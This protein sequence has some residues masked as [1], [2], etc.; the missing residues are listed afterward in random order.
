MPAWEGMPRQWRLLADQLAVMRLPAAMFVGPGFRLA[1]TNDA[2]DATFGS[3]VLGQS[4]STAFPEFAEQGIGRSL[5]TVCASGQPLD[6]R[7]LAVWWDLEG[8]RLEGVFDSTYAPIHDEATGEVQ[9]VSVVVI[10]RTAVHRLRDAHGRLSLLADLTTAVG[11]SPGLD[12]ALQH[13]T[14]ALARHLGD[15]VVAN[16]ADPAA[17]RAVRSAARGPD[18]RVPQGIVTTA[19]VSIAPRVQTEHLD[20]LIEQSRHG[21]PPQPRWDNPVLE[22]LE[23]ERPVLR[24]TSAADLAAHWDPDDRDTLEQWEPHSLLIVPLRAGGTTLGALT[25]LATKGR[26][27]YAREDVLFV[28]D[29]VSRVAGP[30]AQSAAYAEQRRAALTLQRSLLPAVLPPI[31]GV[32]VGVRYD[33]GA[34]GVEIGC[35]WYDVV[36]LGAGRA[37][38]VV[39]DVM[40]RGVRAAAVM[41][42]LR[43]A[44]R[45][46]LRAEVPVGDTVGVLDELT[47]SLA[48]GLSALE[49]EPS[50][51]VPVHFATAAFAIW[52][53]RNEQLRLVNAG[54]LPPL[55]VSAD[56][57]VEQLSPPVVAPLGLG[58]DRP[59]ESVAPLPPGAT[60]ALYTDGLVERR[61]YSIE[62]GIDR[63]ADALERQVKEL[64]ETGTVD[65]Q[66]LADGIVS[67]LTEGG[68]GDDVALLLVRPRD[69]ARPLVVRRL[70]VLGVTHVRDARTLAAQVVSAGRTA[71]VA[72]GRQPVD[73]EAV[74]LVVSELVTN[75]IRHGAGSVLMECWATPQAVVVEVHDEGGRLPRRRDATPDEESGRGLALVGELASSWGTRMV[76]DGKVTWAEFRAT[77]LRP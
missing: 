58:A 70:E 39:G 19:A 68:A 63:L 32:D 29:V 73:L 6:R 22:A 69:S 52:E 26:P 28:V 14:D 44:F 1:F 31:P 36:E 8:R 38:F 10:D 67:E 48:P 5:D 49:A 27:A 64:G 9:G 18:D 62:H 47:Q 13:L 40:G 65:L 37:A 45:T 56:G 3:R 2:L 76:P 72:D 20:E 43:T 16:L 17:L 30:L 51:V 60:L 50:G 54:H 35:E 42:Q 61:E 12:E 75:A 23:G 77:R 74:Q 71:W 21:A 66:Q 34:A 33:A 53:P 59:E 15:V 55:V 57:K 46:A 4:A 7:D 24:E 11:E 41:G 25:L